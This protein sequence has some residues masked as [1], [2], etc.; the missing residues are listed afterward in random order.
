MPIRTTADDGHEAPT[1]RRN[2]GYGLG[3][4][5]WTR[6]SPWETGNG[7]ARR[8]L[9]DHIYVLFFFVTVNRARQDTDPG[10]NNVGAYRQHWQHPKLAR[11]SCVRGDGGE[12][13][14]NWVG[15]GTL[16]R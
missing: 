12:Q 15:P 4:G 16:H 7:R 5:A 2:N 1:T 9:G 3:A 13:A 6:R 11:D 8:R 10:D 14:V